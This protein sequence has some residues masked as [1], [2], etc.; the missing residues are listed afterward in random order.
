MD[1]SKV[2]TY[3][4]KGRVEKFC[5][6]DGIAG[7]ELDFMQSASLME[8]DPDTSRTQAWSDFY[9]LKEQNEAFFESLLLNPVED[10]A[11]R[12]WSSNSDKIIKILTS[13][14]IRNAQSY[15]EDDEIYIERIIQELDHGGIPK[16]ILSKLIDSIKENPDIVF[17]PLKFLSLLKVN[18]PSRFLSD[19][20]TW[21]STQWSGPKEVILSLYLLK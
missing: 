7:K 8:C 20:A 5:I 19:H 18:I 2:L 17:N 6:A 1:I 15:T 4:R 16:N 13:S 12:K 14:N 21:I 10:I 3:F 11:T 9:T